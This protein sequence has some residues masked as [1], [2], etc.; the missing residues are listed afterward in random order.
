MLSSC[1]RLKFGPGEQMIGGNQSLAYFA[2]LLGNHLDSLGEF[3]GMCQKKIQIEAA[4]RIQDLHRCR[5]MLTF[6]WISSPLT[7]SREIKQDFGCSGGLSHQLRVLLTRPFVHSATTHEIWS[8][9]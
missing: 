8:L 2:R 6:P 3:V 1:Y 7:S 4:G 9:G 5:Q